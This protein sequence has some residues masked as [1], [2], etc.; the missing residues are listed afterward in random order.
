LAGNVAIGADINDIDPP[1]FFLPQLL[2]CFRNDPP[3]Y[4]RLA[5]ADL[6]GDEEAFHRI[7]ILIKSAINIV[8]CSTL[9]IL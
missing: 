7:G 2:D 3:R 6:I 8:D 5:Q 9:E 4:Q 1:I